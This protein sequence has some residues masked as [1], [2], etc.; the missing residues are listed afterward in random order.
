MMKKGESLSYSNQSLGVQI[1]KTN[2]SPKTIFKE[3]EESFHL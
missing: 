3:I 1:Q 2:V